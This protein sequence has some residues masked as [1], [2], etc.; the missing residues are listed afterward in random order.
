MT[1]SLTT[2]I[3]MPD[4]GHKLH[5]RRPEGVFGGYLDINVV[6]SALVGSTGRSSKGA[7]QMCQIIPAPNRISQD[8]RVCVRMDICKL[9]GDTAGTVR[10]HGEMRGR[11][12]GLYRGES[13]V[14]FVLGWREVVL[15][16]LWSYVF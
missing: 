8:L 7:S 5:H 6:R 15:Y 14:L 13:F 3:R 16:V 11:E 1:Y 4:L 2:D 12:S 9:L 10:G